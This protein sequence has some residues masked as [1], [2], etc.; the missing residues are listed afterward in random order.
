[1]C[2]HGNRSEIY[3]ASGDRH[4]RGRDVAFSGLSSVRR[5][6]SCRTSLRT[7]TSGGGNCYGAA[8]LESWWSARRRSS[9]G[10]DA[11][12]PPQAA[13]HG[14]LLSKTFHWACAVW[15]NACA[16]RRRRRRAVS[17]EL[18]RCRD[19]AT[20]FGSLHGA[21][22]RR[23]ARDKRDHAQHLRATASRDVSEPDHRTRGRLRPTR[24]ARYVASDAAGHGRDD[25]VVRHGS[26]GRSSR[27]RREAVTDH[28]RAA[29][30]T[31]WPCR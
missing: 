1:M 28:R 7:P 3:G 21:A 26:K 25:I 14:A 2:C 29:V 15:A 23:R 20:D 8:G 27:A 10:K 19:S 31:T 12:Q 9:T 4:A 5:M 13:L 18:R 16:A 6:C 30:I 11:F 17:V 22:G 24:R